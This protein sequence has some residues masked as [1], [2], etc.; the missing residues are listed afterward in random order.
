MIVDILHLHFKFHIVYKL[1]LINGDTE[2]EKQT[3]FETEGGDTREKHC[4][5][6]NLRDLLRDKW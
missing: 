2:K 3:T 4:V 1:L 5:W 6:T